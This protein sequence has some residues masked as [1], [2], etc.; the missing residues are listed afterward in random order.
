MPETTVVTPEQPIEAKK[1]STSFVVTATGAK[2]VLIPPDIPRYEPSWF[3]ERERYLLEKGWEK[4]SA[5]TVLPSYRDPKG[6]QLKGEL[7]KVKD[8]P[9]KGDDLNPTTP[10]FQFHVPPNSYSY[11]LEEALDIQRRR[12]AA[13][14]DGPSPLDRLATCEQRCNDLQRELEAVKGRIKILLTSSHLTFEGL[15]LGLRELIGL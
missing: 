2:Q 8:L 9:N 5:P 4:D 1:Q 10:L 7:R 13:G 6:S 12:D 14:D 11:T 15:K 3:S